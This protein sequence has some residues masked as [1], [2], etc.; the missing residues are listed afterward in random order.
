MDPLRDQMKLIPQ[1]GFVW[2]HNYVAQFYSDKDL[3]FSVRHVK[4]K[5]ISYR[6]SEKTRHKQWK[7][8]EQKLQIVLF[9]RT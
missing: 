1:F 6:E 3:L 7:V 4:V 2:A 9:Q 5:S 8:L